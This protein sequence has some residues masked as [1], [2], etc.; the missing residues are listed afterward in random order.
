MGQTAEVLAR[1]FGIS[2]RDQDEF[3]LI[4]H[5]R[6]VAARERL[7][8]E[9]MTVIPPSAYKDVVAHDNGP[10]ENQTLEALAKLKPFFDKYSGT[11]TA[12]NSKSPMAPSCFDHVKPGRE[13]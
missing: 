6:A 4:S 7:T 2:R 11:V 8:E 9:M 13:T 10:R 1:E 3:S 12:G 5:Q